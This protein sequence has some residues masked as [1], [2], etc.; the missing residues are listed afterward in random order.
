MQSV[1]PHHNR[2]K[3]NATAHLHRAGIKRS[4]GKPPPSSELTRDYQDNLAMSSL[5]LHTTMQHPATA[6]WKGNNTY[7]GIWY[8]LPHAL[9]PRI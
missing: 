8:Q 7:V 2:A 9:W 4:T 1:F 6:S 5:L 3:G